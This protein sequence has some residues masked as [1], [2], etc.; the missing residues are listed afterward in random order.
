MTNSHYINQI[1]FLLR[2][3]S[4]RVNLFASLPIGVAGRIHYNKKLIS[5]DCSQAQIALMTL[6]HEAGHAIDYNRRKD[7]R[8]LTDKKPLRETRAY[9]IG[10]CVLQY[11]ECSTITKSMWRE[12]HDE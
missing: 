1:V 3:F 11:V 10:W 12:F 5:I 8:R 2:Q 9:L 4:W 6:A 7:D